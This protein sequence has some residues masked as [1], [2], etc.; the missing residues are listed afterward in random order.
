M[1]I[2]NADDYGLHPDINLGIYKCIS[3]GYLKSISVSANSKNVDW[4]KLFNYQE[5][6]ILVGTHITLVTEPWKTAN[7]HFRSWKHLLINLFIKPKSFISEIQNE[8]EWQLSEF[9]KNKINITHIDSHQ[10]IHISPLIWPL[11]NKLAKDLNIKRIRLPYSPKLSLIRR[12]L[13]G[14]I[15]HL[16]SKYR[17]RSYNSA[18]PCIG[19]AY[20]GN[21]TVKSLEKELALVKDKKAEL[22]VHIAK[23]GNNAALGAKGYHWQDELDALATTYK[24]G[25]LC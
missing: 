13:P 6:G 5:M 17:K 8:I 18:I 9:K 3:K 2:V 16:L 19:I 7:Y 24:L 20:S 15:L 14:L 12:T 10:H 11:I 4:E 22:I 1:I 21:N 23:T 25:R